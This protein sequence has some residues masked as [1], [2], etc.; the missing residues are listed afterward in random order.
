LSL[1]LA[2]G[3]FFLTT[4]IG[5]CP[6]PKFKIVFAKS[7]ERHPSTIAVGQLATSR[8]NAKKRKKYRLDIYANFNLIF[9]LVSIIGCFFINGIKSLSKKSFEKSVS[10]DI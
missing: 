8:R 7:L 1:L 3:F 5:H 6:L 9:I 10:A 2:F 4:P